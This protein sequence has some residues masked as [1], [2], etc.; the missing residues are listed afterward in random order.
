MTPPR[1]FDTEYPPATVLL[2][3]V[4]CAGLHY[5]GL[6]WT[7]RSLF[8]RN[9]SVVLMYH[10]V[11]DPEDLSAPDTHFLHPGMYVTKQAFEMQMEYISRN[12]RVID[13]DRL[14]SAVK[15]GDALPGACV[16]TLDDGWRDT[17]S[18]A[19]PILKKYGLPATVFLVSDYVGTSRWF[20]PEKISLVLAKYLAAGGQRE[21]WVAGCPTIRRLGLFPLLA[22][23]RLT[24]TARIILFIEALKFWGASD[25]THV[26][27]ELGEVLAAHDV[28]VT[29]SGRLL[30]NWDEVAEMTKSGI[31]FGAHTKTHPILTRV[32]NDEAAQEIAESRAALERH[33]GR[34]C[35]FFCYPNGD[36]NDDVKARVTAH[37]DAAFSTRQ[38]FVQTRDDAYALKRIGIRHEASFTRALIAC[39][40]SGLQPLLVKVMRRSS[41]LFRRAKLARIRMA[42]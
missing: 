38:G 32:P 3:R 14:V 28:E 42:C 41:R 26:I 6:N 27:H 12:Y 13:A 24:S 23:P 22:N 4:L 10:R 35:P 7:F 1:R 30:M 34:P 5:T 29:Y 21:S 25:R 31:T 37:Y 11:I 2:E 16:I 9:E 17:Y 39:K 20:W 15:S 8:K 33:L 19:F 36:Y 40:T 18:C